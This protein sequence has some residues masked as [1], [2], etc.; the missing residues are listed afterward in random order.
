MWDKLSQIGK[1]LLYG[2]SAI[3]RMSEK[4]SSS[5][6]YLLFDAGG[7]LVFP[8]ID[9]ITQELFR[10]GRK[11]D[12]TCLYDG[13]YRLINNLDVQAR[14]AGQHLPNPWPDGYACALFK[15]LGILDNETTRA[16]FEIQKQ[17]VEDQNLWDYTYDWVRK[18]LDQLKGE[19][20]QMSVLSNS[21]GRAE[22]IFEEI[23]IAHYF[24]RI[25]D[26][27]KLGLEKPDPEAFRK[28]LKALDLLPAQVIYIGDYYEVDVKG[29]NRAGI[30][31]IHIDPLGRYK[32]IP[33]VHL[34]DISALPGWLKSHKNQLVGKDLDFFPYDEHE[35]IIMSPAGQDSMECV[36]QM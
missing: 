16:A 11:I 32:N 31:A 33:G 29:A 7:T 1:S 22:E 36:I 25:F 8:N 24:E 12:P 23:N 14:Q 2:K 26:S 3:G 13:Y 34:A 21:D 4:E 35:T 30:A 28:V 17:H 5:H 20:Y 27:R 6:P 19:G 18:T 10:C 15:I 9:K